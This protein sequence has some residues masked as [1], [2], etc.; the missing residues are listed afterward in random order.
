MELRHETETNSTSVRRR[1]DHT[2]FL[3]LKKGERKV[4]SVL[5]GGEGG[6][7]G[8]PLLTPAE[9]ACVR[10][11]QQR[12]DWYKNSNHTTTQRVLGPARYL[13]T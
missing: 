9:R 13:Q 6:R 4:E 7:T 12:G 8:S 11:Q 1:G 5:G 3:R 10:E 2:L